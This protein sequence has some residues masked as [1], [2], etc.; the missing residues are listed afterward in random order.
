M[1]CQKDKCDVWLDYC[2]RTLGVTS[3]VMAP[4]RVIIFLLHLLLLLHQDERVQ[5]FCPEV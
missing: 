3:L 5:I 1:R 2:V 4:L